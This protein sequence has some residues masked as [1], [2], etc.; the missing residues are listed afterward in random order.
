VESAGQYLNKYIRPT[1]GNFL[2][3]VVVVYLLGF[4]TSFPTILGFAPLLEKEDPVFNSHVIPLRNAI[5]FVN[6]LISIRFSGTTGDKRL[7]L[8]QNLV[9]LI[10]HSKLYFVNPYDEIFQNNFI[11]FKEKVETAIRCYLPP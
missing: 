11:T 9:S 7:E 8:C 6:K 3:L 2:L 5:N 4:G 1:C 10:S